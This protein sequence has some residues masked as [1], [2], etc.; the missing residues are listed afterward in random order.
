MYKIISLFILVAT[1]FISTQG[2][3]Q[4]EYDVL[5]NKNTGK[6]YES[7]NV[8]KNTYPSSLEGIDSRL[9]DVY[10]KDYLQQ[11]QTD[12]PDLL[13]YLTYFLDNS[14]YISELPPKK[15]KFYTTVPG[16]NPNNFNVLNLKLERDQYKRKY[17]QLGNSDKLL[18]F[19]SNQEFAKKFNEWKE[20][21]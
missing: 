18:I 6:V 10:S 16:V 8:K 20:K 2:F 15:E 9:L 11:L 21:L 4:T 17:Y 13:L 1:C 19:Y 12:N 5:Y 3:G 7:E 14:F